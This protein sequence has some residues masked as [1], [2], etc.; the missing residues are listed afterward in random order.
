LRKNVRGRK[1]ITSY[2]QW[3][4]EYNNLILSF[5]LLL[6]ILG[7]L[8]I[9][10]AL[11]LFFAYFKD[12]LKQ[13]EFEKELQRLKASTSDLYFAQERAIFPLIG[14]EDGETLEKFLWREF[15]VLLRL[16]EFKVR[17]LAYG[18]R[19][20]PLTPNRYNILREVFVKTVTEM[21]S[22]DFKEKLEKVLLPRRIET[23]LALYF[24]AKIGKELIE[25]LGFS[26]QEFSQS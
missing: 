18:D 7:F 19:D 12:G 8:L 11:Y 10:F 2:D 20:V 4:Q 15:E 17:D 25:E 26:S 21:L 24:D 9:A 1:M 14:S 16:A 22:E 3:L 23:Y 13:L 5:G 6:L